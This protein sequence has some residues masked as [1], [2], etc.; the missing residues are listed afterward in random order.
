MDEGSNDSNCSEGNE[1]TGRYNSL[2]GD[3]NFGT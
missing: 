1:V 3:D 2:R